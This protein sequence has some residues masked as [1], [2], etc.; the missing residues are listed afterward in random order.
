MDEPRPRSKLYPGLFFAGLLSSWVIFSGL[1]DPFHLAL[2]L[3]SCGLVTWLSSDLL[4]DDRTQP[5]RRRALQGWRLLGYVG[6]LLWQVVLANVAVFRLVI[7]G[8]PAL[9]PQIV[10]HETSLRSDFEKFLFANSITLTPGT[11][12][13]KILGDTYFVHAI[14]DASAA[15]LGG[16]MERRIARI[17]EPPGK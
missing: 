14:D 5:L 12:T 15:G 11:V 10:R 9:Q 16:E 7:A 3:A 8:R 2:G 13:M 6:W 4:F 1:L 17:F